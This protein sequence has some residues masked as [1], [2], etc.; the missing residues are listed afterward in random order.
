[1]V[2]A[3][4]HAQRYQSMSYTEAN[5]LA[6]SMIFDIVQ[7]SSGVIWIGRRLGIS[8]YN[9]TSF[10]NYNVSD[11]L[12]SASYA[13]LTIDEKAKIWALPESGGLFLS[14]YDGGKWQSLLSDSPPPPEMT[15][16]YTSLD[17]QYEK[18]TAMIMVGTQDKGFIFYKDHKWNRYTTSDGIPGKTVNCVRGFAGAAYVASD[19]GLT[20][21]RDG[22]FKPVNDVGTGL[23]SGDI[24]SMDRHG[25]FLWL[26]GE[27]WLGY[28]TGGKFTMTASGFHLPLNGMG[29][30]CFLHSGRDGKV[31]FGNSF[32]VFSFTRASG[33]LELLDR[34]N[35][36]ISEG[37]TSALVDRE[38]NTWITGYRGITKIPSERFASFAEENG[39]FSNEVAS[40]ME[41]SPGKYIF[42]HD[43][44]VTFYDGK[45]MTR[46]VL[47]PVRGE[48]NYETRVIEIQKGSN[49][50]LWLAVSSLGVARLDKNRHISWYHEN[51]GLLG[52][53]YSIAVTPS[54]QILAGTTR[55]LFEFSNGRFS[56]VDL[57]KANNMAYR[58]VFPGADGSLYLA[59]INDGLFFKRGK[60]II[61]ITSPDNTLANN[62]F[63]YYPDTKNRQWV[64]TAAGLYEIAGREL[65][66]VN[67]DGLMINRPVYLIL[68]DHSGNLWVGTDNGVY[69]WDGKVL[70]HFTVN[71]GLSGQDINRSAGFTDSFNH[72]WF[73]TNNGVTVFRPELDY[74]PC[75]VPAPKVILLPV[76]VGKDSLNPLSDK[77]LQYDLNDL[78]FNARVISLINEHQVY[79]RYYLEGFDTNWSKEVLYDGSRFTYN[80]LSPGTYRFY[81]KARNSIGTWS[82]QVVSARFIIDPPF[83]LRWWFITTA[84]LLFSGMVYITARFVTTNRYKNSLKE[85]VDLQTLE[86]RNSEMKLMESNAAKD[87][88][89]SII[90]HDLRNP[91]NAILGFLD[92]LTEEDCDLSDAERQTMLLQLKSA[93]VRTIDLLDNLLTWARA[94]RGSLPFEPV[95]FLLSETISD[96][97][98]LFAATA[99]G[100]DIS[101]I[102]EGKD[103][104]HVYADR[105]M[106]STVI[107]NLVS[108]ALKFTYP[109][110]TIIIGMKQQD[111]Q[112]I[113]VYIRDNGVG[114]PQGNIGSLF[115]IEHRTIGMGTANETGT[116]LGLILCKEFIEKN[117]G[118]MDVQS[119]PGTGST[120][121]FTIPCV[122]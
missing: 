27:G 91:F 111:P 13:Y 92:L 82:G 29:R 109:G 112:T 98:A 30:R 87:S 94:Q 38:M 121:T 57:G 22:R 49:G 90:A 63:A 102:N 21:F 10:Y 65:K 95:K 99:Q 59:T 50:D 116:G 56:Q 4:M 69:R 2:C 46:Q 108:N 66:R 70:S 74:K 55:G 36:L 117:G 58:K 89:F 28:I 115:K 78:A 105:N 35:G 120:F 86:L 68:E 100:K 51:E 72:I 88:F 75:E 47:N 97:L 113:S 6:N 37:G 24:L 8:S 53:A 73:G 19:K 64:G 44:A 61:S 31:Y 11:G 110:G 9:G 81:V 48:A 12:R 119:A 32:K 43:G 103:N 107:R 80:N 17:I 101:L 39:L 1:M 60:E 106:I 71:D 18:G 52:V 83:W 41:I 122:G 15:A 25:N 67:K 114:I 76:V 34:S 5:G 42:G 33:K 96:N 54:G 40:G 23:L 84:V 118:T 79:I 85:Q 7:D 26:L 3:E 45:E 20:V 104:C 93:A 77:Q 16:T 62:V 14:Q